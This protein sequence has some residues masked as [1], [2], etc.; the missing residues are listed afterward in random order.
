MKAVLRSSTTGLSFHL[1]PIFKN[2][3]FTGQKFWVWLWTRGGGPCGLPP[4]MVRG[5]LAGSSSPGQGGLRWGRARGTRG[6]VYTDVWA[7]VLTAVCAGGRLRSVL[8]TRLVPGRPTAARALLG[9]NS[10]FLLLLCR[11]LQPHHPEIMK[12]FV[13]GHES[14]NGGLSPPST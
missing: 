1:S 9:H 13:L 11:H 7:D 5:L 6:G 14:P 10:P 2:L 12:S 8:G 3:H 4:W